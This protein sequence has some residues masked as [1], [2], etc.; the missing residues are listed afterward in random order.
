MLSWS[1]PG[2]RGAV[3][4]KVVTCLSM[5]GWP[6]T[7]RPG[8]R[9]P[10]GRTAGQRLVRKD[11]ISPPYRSEKQGDTYPRDIPFAPMRAAFAL[12][13]PCRE[14]VGFKCHEFDTFTCPPPDFQ[15]KQAQPL[16]GQKKPRV[17]FCGSFFRYFFSPLMRSDFV[18]WCRWLQ[19]AHIAA[20]LRSGAVLCRPAAQLPFEP[21]RPLHRP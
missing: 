20:L 15:K 1:M 7:S 9:L 3:D 10:D 14:S 13:Y 19:N 6:P 12:A 4:K 8:S 11:G 18:E 16:S 5:P 21:C 17:H 2:R